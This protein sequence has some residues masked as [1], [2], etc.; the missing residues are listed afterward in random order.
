MNPQALIPLDAT[1][2]GEA[3][4]KRIRRSTEMAAMHITPYP[5]SGEAADLNV[6]TG[7]MLFTL[8]DPSSGHLHAPATFS[9]LNGLSVPKTS[10]FDGKSP[11][12]QMELAR[13]ILSEQIVWCG[14]S[15]TEAIY[16]T[17]IPGNTP[18]AVPVAHGAMSILNTGPDMIRQGDILCVDLPEVKDGGSMNPRDGAFYWDVSTIRKLGKVGPMS[19]NTSPVSMRTFEKWL[20]TDEFKDMLAVFGGNVESIKALY[21]TMTL[22]DKRTYVKTVCAALGPVANTL[23]T[24]RTSK[25]FGVAMTNAKTGYFCDA[26]ITPVINQIMLGG[27][28]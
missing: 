18:I 23:V 1:S 27:F 20:N 17:Q 5:H 6:H 28:Q 19:K 16:D 25:A 14:P 11:D 13:E 22:A 21:A 10:E 8:N 2:G 12:E 7:E 3:A 24:Q 4:S 26:M 15:C 9:C